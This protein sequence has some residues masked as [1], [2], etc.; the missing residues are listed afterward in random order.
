MV[1]LFGVP[2]DGLLGDLSSVLAYLAGDTLDRPG[3]AIL[4]LPSIPTRV[5]TEFLGMA[6]RDCADVGNVDG[7][8]VDGGIGAAASKCLDSGDSPTGCTSRSV[9]GSTGPGIHLLLIAR[10]SS[11]AQCDCK[12]APIVCTESSAGGRSGRLV[13]LMLGELGSKDAR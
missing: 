12:G 4:S 9:G 3:V 7:V 11:G 8:A 6:L 10:S 13:E 5:G 1:F 2:R